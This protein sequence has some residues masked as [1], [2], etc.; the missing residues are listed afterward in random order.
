MHPCMWMKMVTLE[1]RHVACIAQVPSQA[2]ERRCACY[3]CCA[4]AGH[5]SDLNTTARITHAGAWCLALAGLL[6]SSPE[7]CVPATMVCMRTVDVQRL[8]LTLTAN[9]LMLLVG[10]EGH[11]AVVTRPPCYLLVP[12]GNRLGN[13]MHSLQVGARPRVVVAHSLS[14]PPC[15]YKLPLPQAL[16]IPLL[17]P[18]SL[19]CPSPT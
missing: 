8:L 12:C 15:S 7:G 16:H 10:S 3:A 9:V 14:F 17:L 11:I 1:T 6:E 2:L 18:R 5:V 13:Q 4:A 19:G